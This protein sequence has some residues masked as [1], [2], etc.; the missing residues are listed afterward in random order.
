[1]RFERYP[2]DEHIC[3]FRVGSTNMDINYMRFGDTALSFDKSGMNTILDYKVDATK[4]REE[5]RILLYQG[6]NYSVTGERRLCHE[7]S[8]Y[9][10]FSNCGLKLF[11][12]L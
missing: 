11:S 4:L 1:M 2:L 8:V 7:I 5:D 10:V 12:N 3:K 9:L 6:Q